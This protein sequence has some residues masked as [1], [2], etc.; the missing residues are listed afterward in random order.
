VELG[1]VYDCGFFDFHHSHGAAASTLWGLGKAMAAIRFCKKFWDF[2]SRAMEILPMQKWL[3]V[4]GT[5]EF[6]GLL[7]KMAIYSGFSH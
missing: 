6:P 5:M 4:T 2:T 7:L 1:T 3:V